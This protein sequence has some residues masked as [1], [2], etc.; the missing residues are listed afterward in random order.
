MVWGEVHSQ[1]EGTLEVEHL[2]G[3]RVSKQQVVCMVHEVSGMQ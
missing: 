1:G 3:G 2:A